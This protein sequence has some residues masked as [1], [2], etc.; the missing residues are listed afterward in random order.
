MLLSPFLSVDQAKIM[1]KLD[2]HAYKINVMNKNERDH[3][4]FECQF[5]YQYLACDGDRFFTHLDIGTPND[6]TLHWIEQALATHMEQV[7][8]TGP[9]Y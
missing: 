9:R 8:H 7:I 4:G 2:H 3:S 1:M 5:L 6:R